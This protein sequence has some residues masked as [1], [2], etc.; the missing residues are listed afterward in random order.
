MIWD[1]P[2][3][4]G[5]VRRGFRRLRQ[6]KKVLNERRFTQPQKIYRIFLG[7]WCRQGT[8]H[9]AL[10]K[11]PYFEYTPFGVVLR[12]KTTPNGV[13]SKFHSSSFGK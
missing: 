6:R 13:Y 5:F 11:T 10:Y 12:R 1:C 8:T 4:P 3:R 2:K 9:G 7:G